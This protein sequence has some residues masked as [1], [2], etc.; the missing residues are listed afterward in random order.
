MV[1]LDRVDAPFLFVHKVDN[2]HAVD[3]L[4]VICIEEDQVAHCRCVVGTGEELT[5]IKALSHEG[6]GG[7]GRDILFRDSGIA[8]AERDEQRAPL[9]IRRPVPGTV[10]GIAVQA[11][12]VACVVQRRE[13]VAAALALALLGGGDSDQVRGPVA[14]E[15]QIVEVAFPDV[16]GFQIRIRIADGHLGRHILGGF[17]FLLFRCVVNRDLDREFF[18]FTDQDSFC[19]ITGIR[20]GVGTLALLH[21]AG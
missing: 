1:A 2:A 18:L 9:G 10:T 8:Q 12:G 20:M 16:L 3:A 19:F 21:A 4:F 5:L 14:A 11:P 17:V 15:L 13:E 7:I 6:S